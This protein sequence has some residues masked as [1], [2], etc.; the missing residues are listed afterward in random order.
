MAAREIWI[1]FSKRE[2]SKAMRALPQQH[3]CNYVEH[4]VIS[5][6]IKYFSSYLKFSCKHT[7]S[8]DFVSHAFSA[9]GLY[10]AYI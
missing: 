4:R 7:T 10:R 2:L 3:T 5:V 9:L 8:V 6:T 1:Y